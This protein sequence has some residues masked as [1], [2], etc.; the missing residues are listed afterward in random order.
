MNTLRTVL[1]ANRGEIACRIIRTCR[2]LGITTVAV[3]SSADRRARHVRLAD[4][5]VFIGEAPPAQSYL[6]QQRIIQAALDQGAEAIHPGYGFLSENSAFCR[7]VQEAG[8]IFI[9]PD[10]ATIERMG[11]K[12]EAKITMRAA[13]VPVVPG[14]DGGDQSAERLQQE[15]D[16]I[17]YPLLIKASAGGGGKGM[18]VVNSAAEFSDALDAARREASGAFGDDHVILERFLVKPRHV[19]LQIFGDRHGNVVHLFERDCSSQRRYQKIIEESPSPAITDSMREAMGQAAVAAA[20]AVDYV[21]AGTVEFIVQ[22]EEFFFMEMN[23]R[24][25]VEHPVT[26]MITGLDLVEWQLQVAGGAPLPLAQEAIPRRGHAIEVRL[27]A[28]DPSRGFLPS[29]GRLEYLQLPA[30]S[31]D[32]RVDS[33]VE[34]GDEVTV[35]YDPMIAKIIVWGEH[36]E[37]ALTRMNQALAATQVIGVRTNLDFLVTLLNLPLFRDGDIDTTYLDQHLDDMLTADEALTAEAIR[38]AVAG[39]LAWESQQAAN[40]PWQLRDGWSNSGHQ[41]RR[42]RLAAGELVHELTV[43]RNAGHWLL[44]QGDQAT[45]QLADARLGDGAVQVLINEQSQRAALNQYRQHVAISHGGRRWQFQ[46]LTT[47]AADASQE[48]GEGD[49]KAPMPGKIIALRASEG[50]AVEAGDALLVMEAMKMEITLRASGPGI[51]DAIHYRVDDFVEADT[52][53]VALKPAEE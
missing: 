39:R 1:I 2:R 52:V 38:L 15:A 9:G 37:A 49:I 21:G 3:Y 36:R 40:D 35:H 48:S 41:P 11:S 12:A 32:V 24:L 8:L 28:E 51:V 5:A 44:Q 31:D 43:T 22:G 25:Q 7:R 30:D 13:D 46:W 14:Y 53:L 34:S 26:E 18:R 10:H 29:T 6:N 42:W 17:S 27:Y 47:H 50:D 4:R 23:T 45:D 20:R 16:A 19:E 33:G